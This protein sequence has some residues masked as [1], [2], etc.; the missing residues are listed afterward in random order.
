[1]CNVQRQELAAAA[2]IVRNI[3]C[4]RTPVILVHISYDG[5]RTCL[6]HHADKFAADTP[7]ATGDHNHFICDIKTHVIHSPIFL[8]TLAGFPAASTFGGMLFVTRLPAPTTEFSPIVT[9]GKTMTLAP[10]QHPFF[11]TIS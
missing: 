11:S 9:P 6:G 2:R 8:M 5:H 7:R 3:F 1:R 10:S 4:N